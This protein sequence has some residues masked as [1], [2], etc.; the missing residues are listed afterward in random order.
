M[1]N[2]IDLTDLNQLGACHPLEAGI[3]ALVFVCLQ[4][5]LV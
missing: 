3:A 5:M 1:L 4:M 2:P